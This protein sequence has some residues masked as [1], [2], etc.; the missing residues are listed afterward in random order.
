VFTYYVYILA[1]KPGGTLY[2]GI[3][4]DMARRIWEHKNF[5]HTNCFTAKY[6]VTQLVYTEIYDNVMTA[7]LR[8]KKLKN[9]TANGSW[10]LLQKQIHSGTTSLKATKPWGSVTPEG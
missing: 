4:N 9:G 3:T 1:S 10:N 8:E 6:N 5:I 2:V 7:I